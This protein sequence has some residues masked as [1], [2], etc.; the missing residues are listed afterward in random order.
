MESLIEKI[1]N[2][3][4]ENP[5]IYSNEMAVRQQIISPILQSLGWE[6]FDPNLIQLEF[7][8]QGHKGVIK[9][10]FALFCPTIS[11][12][13]VCI[14]EAKAVG[15][16]NAK[17]DAQLFQYAFY[18]GVSLAVVTDGQE[19]RIYLPLVQGNL[20][21]RLVRTINLVRED[22]SKIVTALRRYL[23]YKNTETGKAIKYAKSDRE[24]IKQRNLA[25]ENIP[26]AWKKLTHGQDSQIVSILIEETSSICGY[27]P[28]ADDVFEFLKIE[29]DDVKNKDENKDGNGP[30]TNSNGK[31]RRKRRTS[32]KNV[33]WLFNEMKTFSTYADAYI[34]IME[35]LVPKI[36]NVENSYIKCV[37]RSKS[38]IPN[39]SLDSA[40]KL[41][42]GLWI[43][44][45]SSTATKIN[46]IKNVCSAA[47]VQFGSKS[48][49]LI[50]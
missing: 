14:I 41:N 9:A 29:Q 25:K 13:P 32:S 7:P 33:Y 40:H 18:T 28:N 31:I 50:K 8:M 1:K 15:N 38:D 2:N 17:A 42:N 39:S 20:E 6:I 47:S 10:D 27:P 35:V 34:E 23:S 21:E 46:N 3:L 45:H 19:W 44:S 49:V 12:S 5:N 24:Q 22:E 43:H 36:A 48:G 26:A 16:A 37:Y 30:K 4:R 11:K